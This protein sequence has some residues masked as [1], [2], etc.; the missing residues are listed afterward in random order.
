[1]RYPIGDLGAVIGLYILSSLKIQNFTCLH[2]YIKPAL[3]SSSQNRDRRTETNP[4]AF[5]K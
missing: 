5:L 2:P 4:V 3:T 1:M